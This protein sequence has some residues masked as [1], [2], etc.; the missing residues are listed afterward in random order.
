M[1]LVSRTALTLLAGLVAVPMTPVMHTSPNTTGADVP[2]AYSSSQKEFYLA[3]DQTSFVRPGYVIKVNS[4]TI[5]ADRK[6][7]V[8]VNITDTAGQ[9]L[10][11]LGILTPGPAGT[12]FI[13]AWWDPAT[14]YYT[15]YTT[16]SQTSPITGVTAIQAGTDA[17]GKYTDL[18]M[19]HFKYTFGTALPATYDVTKTTTIGIYG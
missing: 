17:G 2:V 7:V 1:S 14:R 12:S 16:R 4:V 15:S 9:P 10:D 11:R 8:D 5:G 13:A 18:E 3:G 6:P 19:G